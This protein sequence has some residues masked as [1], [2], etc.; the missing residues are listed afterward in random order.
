MQSKFDKIEASLGDLFSRQMCTERQCAELQSTPTPGSTSP[1][2]A[3]VS[4]TQDRG[5]LQ[6]QTCKF[7]LLGFPRK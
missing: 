7:L 2:T 3:R 5:Q 1:R 4:P 6:D